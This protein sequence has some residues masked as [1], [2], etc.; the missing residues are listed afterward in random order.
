MRVA[1][2]TF[3]GFNELDSFIA[4]ALFNRLREQGWQ[5]QITCP[6]A[7]VTSM[8]LSLIHI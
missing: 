7:Q 5:A 6:S 2:L 1:V 3:D 8:N 4:S